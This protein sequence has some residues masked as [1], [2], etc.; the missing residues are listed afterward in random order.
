MRSTTSLEDGAVA[1]FGQLDL[2]S[3]DVSESSSAWSH[4]CSASSVFLFG[5]K[6]RL[7]AAAT[8]GAPTTGI[9]DGGLET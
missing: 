7:A 4:D 5:T 9:E 1:G 8:F 3:R 2:S 6:E